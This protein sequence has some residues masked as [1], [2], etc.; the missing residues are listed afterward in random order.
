MKSPRV[1]LIEFNELCPP[2]LEKFIAQ[3]QLPNFKKFRDASKVYVT[4]STP[5]EPSLEPWIQWVTVHCGMPFSEHGVFRLGDGRKLPAKLVGQCL[6]EAG[7]PVGICASMNTSY[8][9]LP[10]GYFIPDPWTKSDP[11]PAELSTFY[12]LVAGQVQ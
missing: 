8:G 6:S 5:D 1:V 4:D 10:G 3:G 7:I 12:D 11:Y 2:L 9:S